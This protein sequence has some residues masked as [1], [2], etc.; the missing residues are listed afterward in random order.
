[1][2][3]W[4]RTLQAS[5]DYWQW[6]QTNSIASAERSPTPLSMI[7]RVLLVLS[8]VMWMYSSGWLSRTDLSVRPWKRIL[9]SASDAFEISSRR[10]TLRAPGEER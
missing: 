1:M 10:K 7:V 3:Y 9:S 6:R 4:M 5:I 2:P 8:G